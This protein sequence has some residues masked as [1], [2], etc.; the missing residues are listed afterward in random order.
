MVS[1]ER[2]RSKTVREE[3][4]KKEGGSGDLGQRPDGI[5]ASPVLRCDVDICCA[6]S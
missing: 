2:K 1:S 5:R 6:S 4:V 3:T